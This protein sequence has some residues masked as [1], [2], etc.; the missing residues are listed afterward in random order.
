MDNGTQTDD[1][2]D[3][4]LQSFAMMSLPYP[5]S[6]PNICKQISWMEAMKAG[7]GANLERWKRDVERW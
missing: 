3:D 1:D 6:I 2:D 4:N 5:Y 7:S